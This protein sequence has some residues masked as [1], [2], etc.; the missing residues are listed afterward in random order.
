MI[1]QAS[2]SRST[3]ASH[4]DSQL[5]PH[6]ISIRRLLARLDKAELIALVTRW[7]TSS[8]PTHVP[9]VL[10]RRQPKPDE[11]DAS[12]ANLRLYHA[13][14]D[15][16]EERRARSLDELRLL[17]SQPMADPK[18]PKARAINRIVDIDWPEGLSYA[19]IAELELFYASTRRLT[20]TWTVVKMEY[21]DEGAFGTSSKGY[22]RL[23]AA[24]IKTRFATEIGHYFE[25]HVYLQTS[26]Q[27]D[28]LA[29]NAWMDKFS[30]FRVVLAPNPAD[31]CGNGLHIL[32]IP[33]T[34][35]L[36]VS[37]TLGR[38]A[39]TREMALSAFA[40]AA[41][42][43]AINY[44]KAAPGTF[45]AKRAGELND[46]GEDAHGNKRTLGETKGKDPLAL[47]QVLLHEAGLL[48][49][50]SAEAAASSGVAGGGKSRAMRSQH[51]AEDG[52]LVAPLK[53]R[54]EEDI[55]SLGVRL[56]TP[57]PSDDSYVSTVSALTAQ[58]RTRK[59]D[60]PISTSTPL[61]EARALSRDASTAQHEAQREA[62]ELFGKRKGSDDSDLPRFERIEYEMHLPFPADMEPYD[63]TTA[64]TNMESYNAD[65]DKNKI[66]LRLEGTHVLAGLRK[67]IAAGMDRSTTRFDDKR[68][69]ASASGT[70][71]DGLPG[72]LTEV[73]GTKVIVAPPA[74]PDNGSDGS[75]DI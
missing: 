50:G 30:Y 1:P 38:G 63:P 39:E 53:R 3:L 9:P 6:S 61:H 74:P 16:N 51:G 26:S 10:S 49:S 60:A 33:R 2:S 14:L 29:A 69:A 7:L 42:A 64:L 36:L 48:S 56:P 65:P 21:S 24:Q 68:D 41:G 19:M 17:W 37:G 47:R 11:D 70:R 31:V 25:H 73:R 8:L 12:S 72:W 40:T 43:S 58:Q 57:P 22:D 71:L 52:P 28:R 34:P 27:E 32:H 55:Y 4:G 18:V 35:F 75:R 5:V 45:A 44:A 67:L 54:R 46:N 66:K 13:V 23:N 20:R 59:R 15:L 62:Q